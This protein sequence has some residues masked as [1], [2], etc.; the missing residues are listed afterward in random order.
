MLIKNNAT[1]I[2]EPE[3]ILIKLLKL[4]LPKTKKLINIINKKEPNTPNNILFRR[5]SL[6]FIM[7]I[8]DILTDLFKI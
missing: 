7:F 6:F 5:L 2:A 3:I 4:F 1:A 8:K